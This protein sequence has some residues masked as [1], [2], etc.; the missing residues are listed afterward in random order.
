MGSSCRSLG[1]A[2]DSCE[3]LGCQEFHLCDDAQLCRLKP[4]RGATCSLPYDVA[5]PTSEQQQLNIVTARLGGRI[6]ES[7]ALGGDY[8]VQ[9][10]TTSG[11]GACTPIPSAGQACGIGQGVSA[12]CAPGSWCDAID[13]LQLA[14]IM[15]S[16]TPAIPAGD[17]CNPDWAD[18]ILGPSCA[19]GRCVFGDPPTCQ[20]D[21]NGCIND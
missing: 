14:P 2:G 18:A 16:C 9:T 13:P 4:T 21:P 5:M 19:G 1:G 11:R 10:A 12:L 7:N 17:M 20:N 6:N 3:L 8:C 15:G